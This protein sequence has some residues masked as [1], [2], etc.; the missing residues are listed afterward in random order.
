M[1]TFGFE[2]LAV[3]ACIFGFVFFTKFVFGANNTP[4]T[5]TLSE[6]KKAE[7]NAAVDD[8][9]KT[10]NILF[11]IIIVPGIIIA[12]AILYFISDSMASSGTYTLPF[13]PLLKY[14]IIFIGTVALANV[15]T[16]MFFEKTRITSLWHAKENGHTGWVY[17]IYLYG[18]LPAILYRRK[19]I[20]K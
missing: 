2:A 19:Y 1:L 11:G 12:T 6:D 3:I 8:Y 9:I 7:N 14:L 20:G 13:A 5:D 16:K 15:F 18:I 10:T 17:F 4:H